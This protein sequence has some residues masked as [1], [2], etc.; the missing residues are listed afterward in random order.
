MPRWVQNLAERLSGNSL[1][2][3]TTGE[4]LDLQ[5]TPSDLLMTTFLT[6]TCL[7]PLHLSSHVTILKLLAG[8]SSQ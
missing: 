2:K 4:L 5:V 6:C 3:S 1:F 7:R 8:W